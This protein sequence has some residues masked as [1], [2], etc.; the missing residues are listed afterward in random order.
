MPV[1]ELD[2]QPL[3]WFAESVERGRLAHAKGELHAETATLTPDRANH[4]L[5]GNVENRRPN[6][7][8]IASIESA[9]HAD[10][11]R[12]NGESVIVSVDGTLNDGQNRLMAIVRARKAVRSIVV[13]GAERH[14]RFTV[15]MGKGR[16]AGVILELR[17]VPYA[18][19]MGSIA[20]LY[21]QFTTQDYSGA[22]LNK[23]MVA[24]EA[25]EIKDEVLATMGEFKAFNLPSSTRN[26]AIVAYLL[27]RRKDARACERFFEGFLTGA[28]LSIQS[29]ILALR[30]RILTTETWHEEPRRRAWHQLELFI[31]HWNLWRRGELTGRGY[32]AK[33][34]SHFP[35]IQ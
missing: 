31:T 17:G 18:A 10:A 30:N 11:W 4:M 7:K 34:T 20:N 24:D 32:K 23:V 28:R 15:D 1:I 33:L 8:I 12:L 14:S 3:S 27:F 6:E 5:E 13:F 29:P 22:R 19:R 26:A 2:R 25:V 9:I 16:T 21:L 35:K